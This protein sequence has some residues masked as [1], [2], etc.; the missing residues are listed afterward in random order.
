MG[1]GA[2]AKTTKQSE[3]IPP[4]TYQAVCYAVYDIG[5]HFSPIYEK[6]S[7]KIIII[8]ELPELMIEFERDGEK[9]TAPRVIS[10]EYTLSIGEK[11]NLRKDLQC[12][13]GRPFTDEELERFELK[14]LLGANCLL[15]IINTKKENGNI[16]SN[17]SAILPLMKGMTKKANTADLQ[18]FSMEEGMSLPEY[19]PKW[20]KEKIMAS[21]E[22]I[23]HKASQ[24]DD[25]IPPFD[26]DNDSP[27]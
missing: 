11:S 4:D 27:F 22:F 12:W 26:P 3:P 25:D 17:I 9:K 6:K 8:W 13:R 24:G 2:S 21:E 19:T 18:F 1:L 23:K 10:K 15:Q 14:N 7:H 5:T 16:Y 20:I